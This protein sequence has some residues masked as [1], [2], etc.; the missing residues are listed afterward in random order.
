MF[1]VITDQNNVYKCIH[2]GFSPNFPNGTPSTIKPSVT[3]TSGTFKTSDG[4]IWKYMFSCERD[5]YSKFQTSNYIPVTPNTEVIENSIPGTIDNIVL[6]NGGI[7]YRIFEEG[8]LKKFGLKDS[9]LCNRDGIAEAVSAVQAD[10]TQML[11]KFPSYIPLNPLNPLNLS[12]LDVLVFASSSL[13]R[14]VYTLVLF[15]LEAVDK[16]MMTTERKSITILPLLHEV[17]FVN[18]KGQCDSDWRNGWMEFLSFL[19][20]AGENKTT[21]TPETCATAETMIQLSEKRIPRCDM[22][23]LNQYL[24]D[25][26]AKTPLPLSSIPINWSIYTKVKKEGLS[27][28]G[29][30]HMFSEYLHFLIPTNKL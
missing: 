17:S 24:K 30:K 25:T 4:Y 1:F 9:L 2:N 10:V 19:P 7:G 14:C 16:G 8:F 29:R 18:K 28:V 22:R 5:V 21:C 6:M 20:I 12:T 27:K 23:Q 15:M 3:D 13:R 26:T 11:P